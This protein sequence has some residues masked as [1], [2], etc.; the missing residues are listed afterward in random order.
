MRFFY[1]TCQIV[2]KLG[3]FSLL[4]VKQRSF[5]HEFKT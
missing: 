4:D 2:V 5:K 3:K 1:L